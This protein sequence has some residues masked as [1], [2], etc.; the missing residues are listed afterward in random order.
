MTH[1]QYN[2]VTNRGGSVKQYNSSN[3]A[4]EVQGAWNLLFLPLFAAAPTQYWSSP[5]S[6]PAAQLAR[7]QLNAMPGKFL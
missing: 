4:R 2:S 5:I 6:S 7:W 1:I 3:S